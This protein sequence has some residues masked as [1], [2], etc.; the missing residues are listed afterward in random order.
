M[1]TTTPEAA[2]RPQDGLYRLTTTTPEELFQALGTLRKEAMD[3]V[4]RLLAFLDETDGDCD[5]EEEIEANV[6]SGGWLDD[7]EDDVTDEPSLGWTDQE[8]ARGRTYAGC[9]GIYSDLEDEHDGCEVEEDEGIDD[10]PHDPDFDREP[11]LASTANLDQSYWSSGSDNDR[12]DGEPARSPQSRT[13]IDRPAI[14]VEATYR[15]L[16]G[17]ISGKFRAKIGGRMIAG[18]RVTII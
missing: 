14:T 11:S 6:D 12:E 17:G 4:E 1:T 7:M 18:S 15:K 10:K 3:E 2:A 8:A 5:L 13:V 16:V 9:R